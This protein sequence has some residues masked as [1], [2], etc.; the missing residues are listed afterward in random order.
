MVE[1]WAL[2]INGSKKL[3][4]KLVDSKFSSG[5][6]QNDFGSKLNKG[7]E[8]DSGYYNGKWDGVTGEMTGKPHGRPCASQSKGFLRRKFYSIKYS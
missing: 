6:C 5:R 7:R 1:I 4:V 8:W 3:D 2:I